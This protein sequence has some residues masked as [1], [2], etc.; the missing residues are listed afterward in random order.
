MGK[1]RMQKHRY[2][3]IWRQS[4][5]IALM[6]TMV[7]GILPPVPAAG[8]TNNRILKNEATT[9]N[10][11]LSNEA[12]TT[13]SRV[14]SSE[15]K[16][17]ALLSE[18]ES[19]SDASNDQEETED[20]VIVDHIV[21][22]YRGTEKKV[23]IPDGVT[24]IGYEAFSD[25]REIESVVIPESV[26]KINDH[27]F[28]GCVNLTS[29]TIPKSVTEIG[30]GAF[31]NTPWLTEKRNQNSFVVVNRILI[32]GKNCS[33]EITIPQNIKEIGQGAFYGC[34]ELTS[35]VIPKSV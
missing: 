14:L 21:R 15:T 31:L 9:S 13:G 16:D 35:V 25:Y 5:G 7:C 8:T 32:D 28:L 30:Y 33:G 29:I 24:E 12:G 26:T 23:I 6:A 10:M 17:S 3:G 20:F 18:S 22:E 1:K 27:A 4:L 34:K 2:W 11:V 19:E